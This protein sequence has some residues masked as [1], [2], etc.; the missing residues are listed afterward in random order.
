MKKKLLELFDEAKAD[1]LDQFSEELSAPALP[2]E[3]LTAIKEKVYAKTK[4]KNAK[5]IWLRFGT[6]AVCFCLIVSALVVASILGG[7]EQ[8]VIPP[9]VKTDDS[10]TPGFPLIKTRSSS[11]PQ[12]YGS[13]GGGSGVGAAISLTGL[14]VTAEFV[15]MLPD[16]YTYYDDWKQN[17]YRLLR[18]KTTKLLKGEEMAEEFYFMVPVD[19]MTDFSIFY[20]FVIIDMVQYA[21]D[22]SV[23]YNKTQDKAE[24]LY[25]AIFCYHVYSYTAMGENFLAYDAA[26]NFDN[27]LWTATDAWRAHTAQAQPAK[28]ITQIEA[29]VQNVERRGGDGLYVHLLSAVTGEGAELLEEITSFENGIFVPGCDSSILQCSPDVQFHAVRYINGF[30]TNEWVRICSPDYSG[31]V[32]EPIMT[33]ARF[34]DNDLS[35]LPDLSSAIATVAAAYD[36][37]EILPPHIANHE[38]LNLARYGIFG[39]YAKTEDGVLG[40]VRVTWDYYNGGE[41]DAYYIVEYGAEECRPIDREALLERLGEYEAEYIYLGEYNEKGRDYI[42]VVT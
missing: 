5:R 21:Y 41:D 3:I 20:R 35:V 31:Y 22:Y 23:L 6:I 9:P 18:L 1:E 42:R 16:T 29:Y 30:A 17:E 19:F 4:P 24:Q 7:N 33:K 11:G 13:A 32:Q 8:E 14:S 12:Y 28:T 36:K 37:G 25:L 26:G 40:I 34:D 27:R 39:W 2:D 15:E 38:E 10:D